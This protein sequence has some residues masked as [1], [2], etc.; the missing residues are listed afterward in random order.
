L[1]CAAKHTLC[2][3]VGQKLVTNMVAVYKMYHGSKQQKP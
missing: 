1:I 3:M 2:T